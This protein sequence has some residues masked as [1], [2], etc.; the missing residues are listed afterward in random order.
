MSKHSKVKIAPDQDPRWEG[1]RNGNLED[2]NSLMTEHM[3]LLIQIARKI[4]RRLA[5]SVEEG[6][7]IS[8]GSFGLAKA[9]ETYDPEK[10]SFRT[11]AAFR[12]NNAI[13]DGLRQEDW[14][15]KTFRKKLKDIKAERDRLADDLQREPTDDELGE[16]FGRDGAWI[17]VQKRAEEATR[18]HTLHDLE[19]QYGSTD[20]IPAL[21]SSS[22]L[23]E[24]SSLVSQCQDEFVSWLSGLPDILKAIWYCTYYDRMSGQEC[25][26]LL[27]LRTYEYSAAH[28]NLILSFDQMISEVRT[29]LG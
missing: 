2:R 22:H 27:G 23:V 11:H 8:Y 5:S 10:A 21:A 26:E 7:L 14:A 15:P 24:V 18:H 28:K 29:S 6:D 1:A 16:S 25:R 19:E 13:Y 4:I 17:R 3:P 12:I 20:V 9:I